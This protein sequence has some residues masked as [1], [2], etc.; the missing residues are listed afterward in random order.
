MES[1]GS[2]LRVQRWPVDGVPGFLVSTLSRPRGVVR[3]REA[4]HSS[5][6]RAEAKPLWRGTELIT[7]WDKCTLVQILWYR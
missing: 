2:A 6:S 1:D 3:G 7:P 4:E 5:R